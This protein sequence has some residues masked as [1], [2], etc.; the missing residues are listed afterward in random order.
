MSLCKNDNKLFEKYKN[1]LCKTED[2]E[3]IKLDALPIFDNNHIK[4]ITRAH[5]N[6]V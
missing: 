5:G 3:N 1:I 6:K 2:L 4:T